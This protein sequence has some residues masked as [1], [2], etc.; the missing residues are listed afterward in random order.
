LYILFVLRSLSSNHCTY[1]LLR[2]LSFDHCTYCLLCALSSY[3]LTYCLSFAPCL[4]II[5]HIVCPSF[6][7]F[8]SSYILFVLRSLS[9]NHCTSDNMYNDQKTRNEGDNMYNDQKTKNEGQTICTMI[10]RQRT[11][12]RQYVQW[13]EDKE[14]RTNNMY[15]DQKTNRS[16]SS[17]HCTYCLSFV[18]C[19]LLIV[20][21]FCPSFFVFWSLYIGMPC[22]YCLSFFDLRLLITF[23]ISSPFSYLQKFRSFHAFCKSAPIFLSWH[24]F[25]IHITTLLAWLYFNL[26]VTIFLAWYY[27]N[28]NVTILLAWHYFNTHVTILLTLCWNNAKIRVTCMLK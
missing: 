3:H 6:F 12:E 15:N 10:R 27:F 26:N 4:L 9:S 1:C 20:H 28:I 17:D 7:V 24:Y 19:L 5:V 22:T 25:N 2:S 8:W 14:R 21:I 23:L 16:L 13:L 18:L 11:K